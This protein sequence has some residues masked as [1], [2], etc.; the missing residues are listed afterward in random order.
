MDGPDR[1]GK[2]P[3][4]EQADGIEA[5]L[6][7]LVRAYISFLSGCDACVMETLRAARA[8]DGDPARLS[9]LS[10]WRRAPSRTFSERERMALVWAEVVAVSGE[11][12]IGEVLREEIAEQ[13]TPPELTVLTRAMKASRG[14]PR[15]M[16]EQ[17]EVGPSDR[18]RAGRRARSCR[19]M[20]SCELCTIA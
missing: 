11:D 9:L 20:E 3:L 12:G 4:V 7:S 1:A 15:L 2:T 5:D 17:S 8:R 18:L 14:Y 6:Y 10:S 13:F 19:S 16:R